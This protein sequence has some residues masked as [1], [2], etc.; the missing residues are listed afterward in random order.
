MTL[1]IGNNKSQSNTHTK[2]QSLA[3]QGCHC[4]LE[5]FHNFVHQSLSAH[6][7]T[8][9]VLKPPVEPV[10]NTSEYLHQFAKQAKQGTSKCGNAGGITWSIWYLFPV[11]LFDGTLHY[12]GWIC[13]AHSCLGKINSNC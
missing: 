13:T 12:S 2:K 4:I 3:L 1:I 6:T 8:M 5:H 9:H 7:M 10:D 11:Q